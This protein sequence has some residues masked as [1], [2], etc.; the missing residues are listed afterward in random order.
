[1]I[2][3]EGNWVDGYFHGLGKHNVYDFMTYIGEFDMGKRSG[4]GQ[5]N[6][7]TSED[8]NQDGKLDEYIYVGEFNEY[9]LYGYEIS[10]HLDGHWCGA[11]DLDY[12]KILDNTLVDVENCDSVISYLKKAY[13]DYTGYLNNLE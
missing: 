3:Y 11:F 4:W 6:V 5:L 13:P 10:P 8:L 9:L 2:I 1:M 7:T 12:S